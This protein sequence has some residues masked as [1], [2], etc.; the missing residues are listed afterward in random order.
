MALNFNKINNVSAATKSAIS[1]KSAQTLPNNPSE[2]GY[3]AEEI[4]RRFY[5]PILDAANSALAEIDRVVNEANLTFS[6]VSDELDNF[7][8]TTKITEAY[9]V[10]LDN[11]SWI[12]N[13]ESNMYEL[14]V[15]KEE[16][17]INDYK[18]IG[19]NMFLL[20]GDGKYIQVNQ[21]EVGTDGTIRCF[22]ETN[23]AGYLSIYVKREGFIV[24][25]TIVDADHVIGLAKVGRT[26][27]F[28]DLDDLP[29]LEQMETNGIVLSKIISGGQPVNTAKY[30]EQS[31]TATYAKTS[32]AATSADTAFT[33]N[34]AIADQFGVNIHNGYSKQNG[35]YPNLTAGKAS[36]AEKAI[37]DEDG[38]NIKTNYSKQNGTYPD[39]VVGLATNATNA[40]KAQKATRATYDENGASFVSAYAKKI[41]VY[42]GMS[43]GQAAVADSLSENGKIPRGV[44][45]FTT[46]HWDHTDSISTTKHS[47]EVAKNQVTFLNITLTATLYIESENYGNISLSGYGI[48]VY[49]PS[50]NCHYWMGNLQGQRSASGKYFSNVKR[51]DL[52]N[53]S[54]AGLNISKVVSGGILSHKESD[55]DNNESGILCD[56]EGIKNSGNYCSYYA[57]DPG[58]DWALDETSYILISNFIVKTNKAL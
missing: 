31:E 15:T 55:D 40:T 49:S 58:E 37:A 24:G 51:A 23:G 17:K 45:G 54:I 57:E 36:T 35:N 5:Q 20:D 46:Q 52:K 14:V 16:H 18:E 11:N 26:N 12:F 44:T 32:G 27:S 41:G 30:A 33:A 8:D 21:F 48:K 38:I 2:R 22:H 50:E 42:N 10:E 47:F 1:R 9:K 34:N 29:N 53:I 3:S 7:I 6:Q 4:K 43:V 28:K 25:N 19:V 39:M 13:N 56:T